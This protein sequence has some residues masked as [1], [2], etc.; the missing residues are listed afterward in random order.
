MPLTYPTVTT[1]KSTYVAP[2]SNTLAGLASSNTVPDPLNDPQNNLYTGSGSSGA[3]GATPPAT[4][5]PA[6]TGL[7][8]LPPD[9]S[10]AY[11]NTLMGMLTGKSFDAKALSMNAGQDRAAQQL[12]ARTAGASVGMAG[13]GTANAQKQSTEATIAQAVGQNALDTQI[14]RTATQQAGL[15]SLNDL[16][17]LNQT[18][19][20]NTESNAISREQIAANKEIAGMNITSSENIAYA[21]LGLDQ[22]KFEESARQ[23]GITTE[24]ANSQFDK[25]MNLK[26]EELTTNDKQFLQSLGL[27]RDKFEASKD[28]FSKTLS[29]NES[30]FLKT[31]GLDERKF[32]QAINEFDT[33]TTMVKDH[34]KQTLAKDYASMSQEDRQFIESLGLDKEK[35]NQSKIEFGVTSK[36]AQDSIDLNRDSLKGYFDPATGQ[37]VK[38]SLETAQDMFGLQSDAAKRANDELYGKTINGVHVPGSLEIAAGQFGLQSTTL[39]MQQDELY[40]KKNP[41][42]GIRSGGSYDRMN[43]EDKRAADTLYGV[44]DASG[45]LITKGSLQVAADSSSYEGQVLEMQKDELYGKVD[46]I[47]GARSG[48]SYDR[49]TDAAKREADA[50]YGYTDASGKTVKGSLEIAADQF[51]LQSKTLDMQ[52]DELYGQIDPITGKRSGG[53]YDRLNAAD[54]READALYGYKDKDGNPVNGSMQNA[55]ESLGIQKSTLEMQKDEL[56]G[57]VNPATGLRSGGSY[58]RLND[59]AKRE[60]DSL[61]GK[62][63]VDSKGNVVSHIPGSMEIQADLADIQQQGMTLQEAQVKGYI[64]KDGKWVKGS[65]EIN[66]DKNGIDLKDFQLRQIST[67]GGDVDANG[68]P[69]SYDDKGAAYVMVNGVK[70]NPIGTIST[71]LGALDLAKQQFGL[72]SKT[73]DLQEQEVLG[74]KDPITGVRSGG[75]IESLLSSDNRADK[76]LASEMTR[77]YG[78][79]ALNPDGTYRLDESGQKIPVV[80]E[81]AFNQQMSKLS[82]S[83][84]E[85]GVNANI[86]NSIMDSLPEEQ[87]AQVISQLAI[88]SGVTYT[89]KDPTTGA[90]IKYE[91]DTTDPDGTVHKAGD[92]V[93]V[94]GLE[95]V[96]DNTTQKGFTLISQMQSGE[97]D[98]KTLQ[99]AAKEGSPKK[100]DYDAALASAPV[101]E[102]NAQKYS[103]G[104][105]LNYKGKLVRLNYLTP[106]WDKPDFYLLDIN[107]GVEIIATWATVSPNRANK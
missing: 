40:G 43:A 23:F 24:Q 87:A 44:F 83:L 86:I 7:N 20:Q 41:I 70:S 107:T 88:D 93:V 76:Q 99:N 90:V 100:K 103:L 81:I 71:K 4:T 55:Q 16:M 78:G 11:N 18:A 42:T 48:G 13:Q 27:D 105:I 97:L 50:L 58:D 62:D 14:Q 21:N 57:K 38:G 32:A 68:N 102:G 96:N 47:T 69:V 26:W 17:T 6:P 2:G 39:E 49:L 95:P 1:K 61:Y 77:L 56:Y 37:R 15:G 3:T 94:K 101:L 74:I 82:Q 33:N 31:F 22:A 66:N 52:I 51:G 35:F 12:R 36:Q 9:L 67:Y 34:F 79:Y 28:Q 104:T 46:P 84:A 89:K 85:R 72:Q 5:P 64:G 75:K 65:M 8:D 73:Y 60:A 53:S 92:P 80:G 10:S 25:T 45:K 29:F 54:K 30:T 59:A 98:Y 106:G 63:V 91:K 19:K